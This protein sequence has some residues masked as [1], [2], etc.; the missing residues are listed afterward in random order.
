M[1]EGG[2]GGGGNVL[3]PSQKHGALRERG[4]SVGI[5]S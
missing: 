3:A 5:I 1:E 2:G 4:V